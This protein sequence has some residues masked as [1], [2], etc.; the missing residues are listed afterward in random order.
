MKD[1]ETQD[2][3]AYE[4]DPSDEN[5]NVLA[6]RYMRL[7]HGMALKYSNKIKN[8][9]T[10]DEDDCIAN[11]H[12]G[13]LDAIRLFDRSRGVG[14]T[15]HAGWR[16]LGAMADGI[17][18]LDWVPRLDR[19]KQSKGTLKGLPKEQLHTSSQRKL[20]DNRHYW[21]IDLFPGDA[22]KPSARE[23]RA[24]WWRTALTSLNR[25]ERLLFLLYYREKLT[26]RQIGESLGISESRVSQLHAAVL[27]RMKSHMTTSTREKLTESM[28]VAN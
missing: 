5:R 2:W 1:D 27:L 9:S 14:F 3:E 11:A 21:S 26:M 18:V 15:T 23:E 8:N 24:D 16:I 22:A 13:L 10:T 20:D 6:E 7:A 28:L 19:V 4:A 25:Q 17:R 12:V